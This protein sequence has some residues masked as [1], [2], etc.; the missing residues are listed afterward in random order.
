MKIT[1]T[2]IGALAI[3]LAPQSEA[4]LALSLTGGNF[5]DRNGVPVVEGTLFQLV[6]LGPDGVFSSIDFNPGATGLA[7]WASGDDSIIDAT[8]V[9]GDFPTTAAFDLMHGQDVAP[10]YM[11]RVL[12]LDAGIP[13]VGTKFG[14]RW[15]PGLRAVDFPN[16]TLQW[17]QT[18][19][20]FTRQTEPNGYDAWVIKGLSGNY[21]LEPLFTTGLGG[22]D[23]ESPGSQARAFSI[24]IPEPASIALVLAGAGALAVLRRRRG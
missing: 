15:F 23:P 13:A 5:L 14:I 17:G 9:G 11:D 12:T 2:A 24:W 6:N 1:V 18:Y 8:L 7:A 4:T 21:T 22:D 20:Q 10:G 19:G 3:L 16:L